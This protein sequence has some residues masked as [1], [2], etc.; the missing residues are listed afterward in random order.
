M[1]D[2]FNPA[3]IARRHRDTDDRRRVRPELADCGGRVLEKSPDLLQSR[4]EP[5]F[6]M[7]DDWEQAMI[8]VAFERVAGLPDADSIEVSAVLDVGDL[9][10]NVSEVYLRGFTT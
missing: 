4:S 2:R 1:N 5:G 9:A 7:L 10:R 6:D 3:L 8:V